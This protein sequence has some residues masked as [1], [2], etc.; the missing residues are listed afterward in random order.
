MDDQGIRVSNYILCLKQ[1]TQDITRPYK[2]N[3]KAKKSAWFLA[4]L[5][6]R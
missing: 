4:S 1:K 5:L 3:F 6:C 2:K